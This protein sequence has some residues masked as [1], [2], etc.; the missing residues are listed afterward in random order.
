MTSC[1]LP[2]VSNAPTVFDRA[3]VRRRRD[4]A[5]PRFSEH[6]FLFAET[7]ER[8]AERVGMVRREFPCVLDLGCHHGV[9]GRRIAATKTVET[10]VSCDLSAAMAARAGGHAVVA[11][12]EALPFAD[13]AFDLVVSTLS[14]HWVNDLP[15]ALIQIRRALRPD[16]LFLGAMLG[17]VTLTE[18]RRHLLEAELDLTG[19]AAPRV[20]PFADLRD[21][22]NLLQRAGFALP[23]ADTEVVTVTWSN[24]FGLLADLRGMGE[25]GA[26]VERPRRPLRRAVLLE[27]A[28][29]YAAQHAEPDGRIPASFEIVHLLGWAP[30]PSQQ[31]PL[32]PGSGRIDLAQVLAPPPLGSEPG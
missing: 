14:L 8:L 7:A 19:G 21:A 25:T 29:R 5:A 26:L 12:E 4:R 31:R 28:R 17:G 27:A 23:V 15:G 3:L 6:D 13:G 16:G 10:L 24:L 2:P 18:L 32:R 22:G 20:S 30:D 1:A 11:D 9:T